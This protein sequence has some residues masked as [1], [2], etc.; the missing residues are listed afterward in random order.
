MQF[1]PEWE[2]RSPW[3]RPNLCLGLGRRDSRTPER[4]NVADRADQTARGASSLTSSAGPMPPLQIHSATLFRAALLPEVAPWRSG[5]SFD[6][7]SCGWSPVCVLPCVERARLYG[8]ECRDHVTCLAG[9]M[10]LLTII[11]L[12]QHSS[13]CTSPMSMNALFHIKEFQQVAPYASLSL[14]A[15]LATTSQWLFVRLDPG[16]LTRQQTIKFNVLI[17]CLL[18]CYYRSWTLDPGRIP[19]DWDLSKSSTANGKEK[20]EQREDDLDFRRRW[21]RRCGML[22]PPRAHH[23]KSCGRYK[24]RSCCLSGHLKLTWTL[25]DAFLKWI[26]TVRGQASYSCIT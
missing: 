18:L 14:I 1:G 11:Y 7:P 16:P 22:K 8:R 17:A 3:G 10:N 9:F 21:C 15:F 19:K 12:Y 26:T 5:Q 20:S 13:L 6:M 4:Q 23:C 24:N 25:V 2:R